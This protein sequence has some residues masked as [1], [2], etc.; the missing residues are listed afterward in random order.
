MIKWL[1]TMRQ[2]SR[3]ARAGVPL[4]LDKN[5]DLCFRL[6]TGA[7]AS[8]V[9]LVS[10]PKSGTYLFGELL[11]HLGV[12]NLDIHIA[13]Y[14]FQDLRFVSKEFAIYQSR[15]TFAMIPCDQVLPLVRPGQHLVSHFPYEPD[16]V[17]Q[18]GGFKVIFT[19]RD[20]RDTL[21]STM[22]WV[23]KKGQAKGSP[24]G[25]ESLPDSPAKMERFVE[26]HGAH[27]LDNIKAMRGWVD[28]PGVLTL[29][30]EEIQGDYGVLRQRE[31]VQEIVSLLRLSR[32]DAEITQA[33]QKSLGK[34]TLT[35]SGKRS[36]REG[37]WSDKVEAFFR[38]NGAE[39]LDKF[40]KK[41]LPAVA[42]RKAS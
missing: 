27:Y 11:T 18:L 22:R 19:Y 33:L 21:V 41:N 3:F 5:D 6:E 35:F 37:L 9:I 1:R 2:M 23:A 20:L 13:T 40:F 32:T 29:S 28:H 8:P 14:G 10:V 16:V 31:A 36:S 34:E 17:R 30:F 39:E 4:F 12:Q 24:E 15:E 42:E 25:W 38:E 7:G 26:K